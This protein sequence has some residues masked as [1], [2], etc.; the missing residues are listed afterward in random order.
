MKKVE[1]TAVHL[2]MLLDMIDGMEMSKTMR[3]AYE[4]VQRDFSASIHKKED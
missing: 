4:A 3:E 2:A 1:I